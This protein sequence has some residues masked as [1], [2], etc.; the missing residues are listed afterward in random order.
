MRIAPSSPVVFGV[1]LLGALLAAT[2]CSRPPAGTGADWILTGGQVVTVDKSFTTARAIAIKGGRIV[3]VGSEDEVRSHM[4]PATRV[5][6]LKGRTVLPGLQDSHIHFLTL[7]RDMKEEADLTLA[8]NAADI[9]D[10]LRELKERRKPKPGE[11]LTG[12]RWDQYKY[13]EMVTR[14]QLDEVAPDNPVRLERTYRGVAV[15]TAVFR[16]MGIED[17]KPSTW[18]SWWQKDPREFTFEDRIIRAPRQIVIDG[19]P[20]EMMVPTG[21]FL[22][23]R[24]ASLVTARPPAKTVGDDVQSVRWGAEEMLRLGVTSVVDPSSRMGYMMKVY[25]EAY[26]RGDML[27]RMAS[28]YEGTFTRTPPEAISERLDAI[29]INNLGDMF[30]RWRGAK[31]YADGGAGTRSAWVS[32]PF[33]RWKELEGAENRG[34]P[35]VAD[36]AV[37]EAQ[38]RAALAHGWELH[39]HACGDVAMRQTVD[40]Y[41]KLMDEIRA[42]N[43]GADL[44]WSVIHAYHPI[45]PK[46]NMIEEMAAHGII[47]VV[48][49]VFN[50]QEGAAFVHN[51]GEERMARTTPFRSIVEEGVIIAAVSD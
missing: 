14:W 43:P 40:L 13:P 4:G 18:P 37:R 21:V 46:T 51:L 44:R 6:D 35:V 16:L 22:G 34:L 11:W 48:N 30:L 19:K 1:A 20:R 41:I 39:T 32:E 25:Q 8:K 47:A 28:V 42:K 45:E 31:F 27:I 3:A 17:D 15:N 7:G 24:A 2:A 9:L 50:W 49:P 29:K 26:N 12:A 23:S 5:V 10:A 38:F 33:E 36:N